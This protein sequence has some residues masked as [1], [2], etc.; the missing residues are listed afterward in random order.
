MDLGYASTGAETNTPVPTATNTP[1]PTATNTPTP[2]PTEAPAETVNLADTNIPGIYWLE[3]YFGYEFG[4]YGQFVVINSDGTDYVKYVLH[5]GYTDE[6][7]ETYESAYFF[8]D[9]WGTPY[10]CDEYGFYDGAYY[11]L[12]EGIPSNYYIPGN[13][14]FEGGEVPVE[15]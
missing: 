4:W 5:Y 7:D 11:D 8:G 2:G 10:I 9:Y 12:V 1:V 3:E 13:V 15:N 14:T 6:Y